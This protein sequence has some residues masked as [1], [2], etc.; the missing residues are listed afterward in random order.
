MSYR[1][2]LGVAAYVLALT[3]S[4]IA[5]YFDTDDMMN[6]Y[7]AWHRFPD[8][9]RPA[10]ALFYRAIFAIAGF[11]PLPFHLAA[12]ALIL[13]NLALLARLLTR[14]SPSPAAALFFGC[15]QGSMWMIYASTGMIY[16]VLCATFLY[17]ALL[18]AIERPTWWP[19]IAVLHIG[20]VGAKELGVALPVLLVLYS[21]YHQRVPTPTLVATTAVSVVFA[22]QRL[23]LP[24]PL[25]GLAAYTPEFT[26]TRIFENITVYTTMLFSHVIPFTSLSAILF[27]LGLFA[28]ARAIRSR[29]MAFGLLFFWLAMSPM[30]LATPRHAGYVFYMPFLGLAI[31]AGAVYNV[32][33]RKFR[34][35][36][37]VVFGLLVVSLHL[38][39]KRVTFRRGETPSGHAEIRQLAQI[40]LPLQQGQRVLLINSPGLPYS[41][42]G[43]FT[44][45]LTHRVRDLTVDE[46]LRAPDPMPQYDHVIRF[47]LAGYTSSRSL[48]GTTSPVST[49]RF[50]S[51]KYI[52][53]QNDDVRKCAL[54]SVHPLC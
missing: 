5:N 52:A 24:G 8:Q 4:E 42:L 2:L 23:L 40:K 30:L 19:A 11:N 27:W 54:A 6:L 21:A 48:Y 1:L 53:Q 3:Y 18:I 46:F 14:F 31:A 17:A 38:Y 45:T 20:A 37:A 33:L 32:S 13:C 25:T 44:L 15:F 16:D 49:N 7:G 12:Y 35:P 47:P 34:V 10:G 39:Q 50:N 28:I 43:I 9:V 36:K 51:R 41:W 29:P 22:A 26:L